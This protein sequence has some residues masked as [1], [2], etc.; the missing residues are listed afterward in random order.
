M[1]SSEIKET[2]TTR[3]V[4][5]IRV[6]RSD[7]KEMVMTRRV[8]LIILRPGAIQDRLF[9]IIINNA[10]QFTAAARKIMYSM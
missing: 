1:I 7:A 10:S 2:V 9:L 8:S 3:R 6:I 4:Y 5:L